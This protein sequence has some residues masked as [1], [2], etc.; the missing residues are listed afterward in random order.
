MYCPKCGTKND[1][2]ARFC[3]GCGAPLALGRPLKETE[4][5]ES[6]EKHAFV[7]PVK[8]SI[9]VDTEQEHSS[10]APAEAPFFV[11]PTEEPTKPA[12]KSKRKNE[13]VIG[14]LLSALFVL[15][16]FITAFLI[17]TRGKNLF[18][19]IIGNNNTEVVATVKEKESEDEATPPED[20]YEEVVPEEEPAPLEPYEEV[21]PE[22]E[23]ASEPQQAIAV[24][25]EPTDVKASSQRAYDGA[26]YY[27]QYASDYNNRTAWVEGVNGEGVGGYLEY[28]IPEGS[29]V[30]GGSITVGFYKSETLL[31]KNSAPTRISVS[32][33]DQ[34]RYVDVREGV[35]EF[36]NE[37]GGYEFEFD[38]PIV[39]NGILRITIE[40][41][42]SGSTWDDTCISELHFFG[43]SH[44]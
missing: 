12:Q 36:I 16:L 43:Y 5:V 19:K 26:D 15:L 44:S 7:D 32:F 8:E 14:V 28:S 22:E 1:D 38:E 42:R 33:G 30:L 35:S 9:T 40:E 3:K 41:T 34:V 31:F 11:K 37:Y 27:P 18:S 24:Q 6:I 23:P 29:M 17:I 10:V 20:L 2:I 39:S 4:P 13:T 21:L 25:L